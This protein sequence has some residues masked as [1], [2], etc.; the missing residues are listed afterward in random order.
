MKR[1]PSRCAPGRAVNVPVSRSSRVAPEFREYERASTTVI[2]AYLVP[3]VSR[4][5]SRLG[6]AVA[7]VGVVGSPTVMRSSGGLIGLDD[8]SALPASIVLSGPVAF[9]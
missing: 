2:N 4:Y 5:L 3:M 6:G 7:G 1:L 9:K 8:A